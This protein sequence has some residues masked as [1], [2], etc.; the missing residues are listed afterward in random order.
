MHTGWCSAWDHRHGSSSGGCRH[1]VG[2]R[3]RDNSFW[4]SMSISKMEDKSFFVDSGVTDGSRFLSGSAFR[5]PR[6][7]VLTALG[8]AVLVFGLTTL[9]LNRHAEH[10]GSL[11]VIGLGVAALLLQSWWRILMLY[12]TIRSLYAAA[13]LEGEVREG[14][15]LDLALR[16]AAGGLADLLF[17]CYG[18]ALMLLVLVGL[19]AKDLRHSL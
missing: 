17:Y 15:S 19:L 10:S 14:S 9:F 3:C 7:L 4:G 12:S 8:F 18:I 16:T 2:V 13:K 11:V 6:F 5:Y 1:G